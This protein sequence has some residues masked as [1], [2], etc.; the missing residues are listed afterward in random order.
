MTDETFAAIEEAFDMTD[1][2]KLTLK[3]CAASPGPK[4]S[5]VDVVRRV[6]YNCSNFKQ[7]Q[8]ILLSLLTVAS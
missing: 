1:D 8:R 3:V 7:V 4:S 2:G 5:L 6:S